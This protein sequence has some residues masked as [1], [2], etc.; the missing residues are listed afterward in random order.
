MQRYSVCTVHTFVHFHD[1]SK[2]SR[3]S[4]SAPP[5]VFVETV[6]TQAFEQRKKRKKSKGK[7]SVKKEREED[8]L[9]EYMELVKVECMQLAREQ[10]WAQL[11]AQILKEGA[12]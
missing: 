12:N 9:C 1:R 2:S 5:E 7:R 10:K 8:C 6:V 4:R 3:R 11:A